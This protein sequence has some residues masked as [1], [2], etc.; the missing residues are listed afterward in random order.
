MNPCDNLTGNKKMH[1]DEFNNIRSACNIL[2]YISEGE[3][4][5]MT[6]GAHGRY[7]SSVQK[8]ISRI[9]E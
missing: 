4:C 2:E 1:N 7:N 3:W 5:R 6:H 9:L 8:K